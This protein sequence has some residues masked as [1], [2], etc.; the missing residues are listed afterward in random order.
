MAVGAAGRMRRAY[1]E[2]P[3]HQPD[4][5]RPA[6]AAGRPA[7]RAE[8]RRRH[9][10]RAAGAAPG[11]TR[12]GRPVPR[13]R[14]GAEAEGGRVPRGGRLAD[15][16]VED[17]DAADHAHHHVLD[18]HRRGRPGAVRRG[19]HAAFSRPERRRDRPRG[20]ARAQRRRPARGG[21]RRG[22][23]PGA[24]RTVP[25]VPPRRRRPARCGRGVRHLRRPR[26]ARAR[27]PG[28]LD[29]PVDLRHLDGREASSCRRDPG[30][31]GTAP[32]TAPG[33]R[34]ASPGIRGLRPHRPA[35]P[36][37]CIRV[38]GQAR[39]R[40]RPLRLRRAGRRRSRR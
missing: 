1:R 18:A 34:R 27:P 22:A 10:R 4:G 24:A 13:G 37:T 16:A 5:G 28:D 2:H 40:R 3:D 26:P 11:G 12:A 32:R 31:G 29:G 38:T 8:R 15:A 20:R 35:R 36:R 14:A 7:A 9:H 21:L 23:L 17:A 19:W 30:D 33:D 25:D 39:V 6:Q